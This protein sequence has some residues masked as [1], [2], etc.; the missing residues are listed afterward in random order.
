M[1]FSTKKNCNKITISTEFETTISL[2]VAKLPE[3]C[4]TRPKL[5]T[6]FVQWKLCNSRGSKGD[7]SRHGL[8]YETKKGLQIINNIFKT[9][10]VNIELTK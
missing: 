8:K 1:L 2:F 6:T 5:C 7:I 3:C 4:I 9:Y 10:F